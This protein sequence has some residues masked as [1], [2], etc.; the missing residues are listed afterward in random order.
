MLATLS[1]VEDHTPHDM[2]ANETVSDLLWSVPF[3]VARLLRSV[4]LLS[5]GPALYDKQNGLGIGRVSDF[6]YVTVADLEN[7]GMRAWEARK[8]LEAAKTQY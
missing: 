5:Y 7:A 2:A 8:L 6:K 3:D 1:Q 4:A